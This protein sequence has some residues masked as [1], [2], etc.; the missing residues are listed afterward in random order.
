MSKANLL[1][2]LP[3]ELRQQVWEEVLGVPRFLHLRHQSSSLDGKQDGLRHLLCSHHPPKSHSNHAGLSSVPAETICQSDVKRAVPICI[4]GYDCGCIGAPILWLGIMRTCREIRAEVE[5]LLYTTR[6]FSFTR[7]YTLWTF[8]KSLSTSQKWLL[9]KLQLNFD[10][11]A[12]TLG[13]LVTL[14][15]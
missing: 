7:P 15:W 9:Q 4:H 11:R 3:P 8:G 5:Y 12:F 13:V 6:T 1:W 14:V 2:K 10:S